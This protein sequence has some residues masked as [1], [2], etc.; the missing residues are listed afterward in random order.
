MKNIVLASSKFVIV[1]PNGR[2]VIDAIGNNQSDAWEAACAVL[3]NRLTVDK[4]KG[5]GYKIHEV[6]LIKKVST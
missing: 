2:S 1:T 3:G 4:M 5:Q 6:Q